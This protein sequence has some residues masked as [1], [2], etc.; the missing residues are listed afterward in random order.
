M[1]KF[2]GSQKQKL[3][4]RGRFYQPQRWQQAVQAAGEMVLTAGPNGSLWMLEW[5]TWEQEVERIG[6]ALLC[7]PDLRMLRSVFVG[8]A[9]PVIADK[10]AR[11]LISEALR[12]Y[13]EL[14]DAASVYL[15][16]SGHL[17]EIWAFGKWDELVRDAK[18][19]QQLFDVTRHSG[20][21]STTAPAASV[22]V[23]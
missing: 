1:Q 23:P 14:T 4:D 11:V 6:A 9:E 22:R 3:D 16:G 10:N 20:S 2:L 5:A 8:H 19:N 13:A 15:I 21:N 7:D 18:V 12:N 17:I